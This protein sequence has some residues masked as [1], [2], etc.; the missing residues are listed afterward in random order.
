MFNIYSF[1]TS[2][3]KVK[4]IILKPISIE[5][6]MQKFTESVKFN[7]HFY[8]YS[9]NQCGK[10]SN[11]YNLRNSMRARKFHSHPFSRCRFEL[12]M[13]Y[14]RHLTDRK[15]PQWYK[16]QF[17]LWINANS[18]KL[19]QLIFKLNVRWITKNKKRFSV[20]IFTMIFARNL[21]VVCSLRERGGFDVANEKQ[22]EE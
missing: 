22:T 10:N 20:N 14:N 5:N 21:L 3:N 2:S 16:R 1:I 15:L 13:T 6:I 18:G 4:R 7:M 19:R 8:L 11:L 12:K 9:K 17:M